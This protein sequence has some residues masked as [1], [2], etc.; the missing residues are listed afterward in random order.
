[1]VCIVDKQTNKYSAF[2]PIGVYLVIFVYF[3]LQFRV[4]PYK[5]AALNYLEA[6]LMFVALI[7][8][9][10]SLITNSN[11]I[12]GGSLNETGLS[13]FVSVVDY[14]VYVLVLLYFL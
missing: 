5:I 3:L 2:I 9:L 8:Y 7:V 12:S 14:A 11:S 6:V 13:T 4:Q 1:M 10:A